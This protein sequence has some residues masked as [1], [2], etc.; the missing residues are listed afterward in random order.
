MSTTGRPTS[1]RAEYCKHAHNY[2][3]LGATKA[4]LAEFFGVTS[5]TIDNWL[6]TIPE[7]RDEVQR[8]RNIAD[9]KVADSL[10]RRAVG[11]EHEVEGVFGR[12]GQ[13]QVVR[14]KKCYPPQTEACVHWLR[15]RR[16]QNWGG[17]LRP[18]R[19][20][21]EPAVPADE[22][23]VPIAERPFVEPVTTED[24][25]PIGG[26]QSAP[27]SPAPVNR[28]ANRCEKSPETPA[29]TRPVADLR[30]TARS[31]AGEHRPGWR[32]AVAPS[33]NGARAPPALYASAQE[34]YSVAASKGRTAPWRMARHGRLW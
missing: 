13:M 33:R 20:K 30:A 1:F 23:K 8:G 7:F 24:T 9:A 10:Y 14:Y 22:A 26:A 11:Y 12:P 15:N 4:Q 18:A 2:C 6:A 32:S 3:L 25:R 27:P 31:S 34:T 5:R 28:A 21:A 16:P 19:L 29:T 17:R